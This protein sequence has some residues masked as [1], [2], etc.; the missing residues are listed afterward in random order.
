VT[1][2]NR[3]AWRWFA[4]AAA[5]LIAVPVGQSVRSSKRAQPAATTTPS[6]LS[7]VSPAEGSTTGGNV[8][9]LLVDAPGAAGVGFYAFA[10]REPPPPGAPMPL[11]R[12]VTRADGNLVAVGGLRAG[13]HTL[14]VVVGDALGTRLGPLADRVSVTTTG[15]SLTAFAEPRSVEGNPWAVRVRLDGVR[16]VPADGDTSGT[17]GHLHFLIDLDLPPAGAVIPTDADNVVHT[18][19][20]TVPLTGL[21]AGDHHVW[22]VAGDGTHR[23]LAPYVADEV[24]VTVTEP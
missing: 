9:Q 4:A 14:T 11:G 17:T 3:V 18:T 7:I 1:L 20:T 24:F 13:R 19:E 2:T 15:P 8:V 22:V 6:S 10:D 5:A 12:G 23:P 16:I 21:G